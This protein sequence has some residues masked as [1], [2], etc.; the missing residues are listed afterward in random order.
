MPNA[1]EAW[2]ELMKASLGL[3]ETSMKSNEML[4][5]SRS[6]ITSRTGTMAAAAVNPWRGDYAELARMIPE[7]VSA[8]SD[9]TTA[10]MSHWSAM[11][12]QLNRH[13][14]HV[15]MT[16]AGYRIVPLSEVAALTTAAAILGA[17]L[18]SQSLTIGG[19]A[20]APIHKTATANA[21]RLS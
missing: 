18:M 4:L 8:F 19:V 15:Q 11:V 10:V 17:S 14:N 21:R 16:F 5:A 2:G 13:I 1:I 7:K 9:A 6:V 3:V 12:E 20:L